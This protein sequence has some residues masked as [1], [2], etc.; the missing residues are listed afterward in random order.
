[1]L[2]SCGRQ[3][4]PLICNQANH[5]THSLKISFVN[6]LLLFHVSFH[7]TTY[8]DVTNYL[9]LPCW[10]KDT[11]S[12][13][14]MMFNKWR[15]GAV[16]WQKCRHLVRVPG[17]SSPWSCTLHSLHNGE[18]ATPEYVTHRWAGQFLAWIVVAFPK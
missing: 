7:E 14:K 11:S 1:M 8:A 12:V 16:H 5:T 9:C 15:W 2:N 4:L 3:T 10:L 17:S 13:K 18:F 6:W